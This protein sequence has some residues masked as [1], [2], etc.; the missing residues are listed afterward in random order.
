M[1]TKPKET[2]IQRAAWLK[3][4]GEAKAQQKSKR[5]REHDERLA[6]EQALAST[7]DASN[8]GFKMMAKLGYKPGATL[9]KSTDARTEP[10]HLSMKEDRGGIGMDSEKKRKMRE[11]IEDGERQEKKTKVDQV[12]YRERL[13]QEREEERLSRQAHAAQKVL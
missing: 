2:S 1:G 6:R 5:E 8:K 13:R 10:N 4:E 12:D 9:G 11:L 7:L 3:K